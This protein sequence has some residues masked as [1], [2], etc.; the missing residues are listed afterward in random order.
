MHPKT[1]FLIAGTA[2][3]AL[4]GFLIVQDSLALNILA[5]GC[6]ANVGYCWTALACQ[7]WKS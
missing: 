5:L 7:I 4:A 3:G 2:S 6:A 1:I